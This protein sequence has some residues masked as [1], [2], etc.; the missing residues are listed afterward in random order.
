M[1]L[2]GLTVHLRDCGVLYSGMEGSDFLIPQ[3]F[4]GRRSWVREVIKNPMITKVAV[5]SSCISSA[6]GGVRRFST[7]S[8]ILPH[9]LPC[10]SF[11]YMFTYPP[12]FHYG[13]GQLVSQRNRSNF[14]NGKTG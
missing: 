4:Q 9:F 6:L 8:L 5:Q 12:N 11:F 1:K 10:F 14:L 2:K 13:F 3:G 7:L